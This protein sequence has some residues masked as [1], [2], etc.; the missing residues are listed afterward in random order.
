[1]SLV[2]SSTGNTTVNSVA[3][4]VVPDS[5]LAREVTELVRDTEPPLLFHHSSRVYYWG[6]LTGRRRGL[7]F[8]PELLY[9]GT[10]FHDMGLTPQYASADKRFEV[11]SANTARDFLRRHGIDAQDIQTVWTAIALHT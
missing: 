7:R 1:M 2:A 5:N 10:M 4:V 8:D 9:A 6:A 3:G 11:D